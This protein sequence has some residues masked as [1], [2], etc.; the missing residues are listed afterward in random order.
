MKKFL[1]PVKIFTAIAVL[2]ILLKIILNVNKNLE[3]SWHVRAYE[4]A[5]WAKANTSAEEVFAMKDAGNFAF[6]SKRKVINLDG[7]V[8]D[9]CFQ[10]FLKEK[11]LNLYFILNN[12]S[13]YVLYESSASPELWKGEYSLFKE[14]L[15]SY[16]YMQQSDYIHVSKE[17]E[18]YRKNFAE[19]KNSVFII[20]KM[21]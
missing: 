18:I 15:T 16:K 6:F 14:S 2:L 7:V 3:N 4:A 8:N 13:Y 20:W 12:I 1:V 9:Y 19:G 21:K 10:E 11:K 17:N 5:M